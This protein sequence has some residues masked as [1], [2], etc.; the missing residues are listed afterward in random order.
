MNTIIHPTALV[1]KKAELGDN[2][3]VGPYAVIEDDVVIGSGTTIGPHVYCAD[4]ARIGKNCTIANGAVVATKPQDLKFKNEK[5][6]FEIGD[7]TTVREFCTLNR[8]TTE[9]MKSVVGSNCL[10]MAYVHVAHDC[11]IG[12]NVILA[13]TVQMGGHVTIEDWAIIGGV[14][15]IHQFVSVGQHVMLGGHFRVTKDVPPYILAGGDPVSFEGLNRIGLQRRGFSHETIE[16][17]SQAYHLLYLS[18][19]NVSQAA[20]KI[21]AELN[22][23]PEINNLLTF[24]ESSERGIIGGKRSSPKMA[25]DGD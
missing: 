11:T 6:T 4:G 20:E 2:V 19:L 7:N 23:I 15:A 9:H 3:T 25:H 12:N 14:T 10:L 13:N 17:L 16:A 21:R 24:I 8:G 18:K 5:T 1:G 22:H